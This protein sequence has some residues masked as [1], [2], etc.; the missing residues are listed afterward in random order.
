M[1]KSKILIAD[2]DPIARESLSTLLLNGQ[3]ELEFANNGRQALDKALTWL[4]DLVLLDAMM[5]WLDGFSVCRQLRDMPQTAEVPILLITALDDQDSHIRGI[6][7]G[8]DDFIS[9][10]FNRSILRARIRTITRLNRY[11][12][13]VAERT[14][15]ERVVD[16]ANNGFLLI[17]EHDE[18]L[19]ANPAARHYL[20]LLSDDDEADKAEF[21]ATVA[22]QYQCH[23]E[24]V[25]ESWPQRPS[26]GQGRYLVRPETSNARDFW[27]QVDILDSFMTESGTNYIISLVDVTTQLSAFRDTSHFHALMSHKLRTPLTSVICGLEI[28]ANSDLPQDQAPRVIELAREGTQRLSKDI[29]QIINYLTAATPNQGGQGCEIETFVTIFEKMCQNLAIQKADVNIPNFPDS[30]TSICLTPQTIEVIVR[31]ILTNSQKFHPQQSPFVELSLSVLPDHQVKI[32]ISDDGLSLSPEQLARVWQ[33]YYQGDKYFTGEVDGV[34][35]GL[36][37]IASFVWGVGGQCRLYN[38]SSGPGVTVE[39]TLPLTA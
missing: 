6:E 26:G 4:P 34:G 1:L 15:F 29:N 25:W 30:I 21:M 28:L 10:P 37:L 20:G 5:P 2:D 13:L 18:I 17:N 24:S 33:P 38:R 8:A 32:Q 35:L 19:F 11:R 39:L 9:K 3:Y 12:H 36:A 23:P 27:L 22:Q 14:K 16:Q 7:A 31:E